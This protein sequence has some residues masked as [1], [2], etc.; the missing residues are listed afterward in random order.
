MKKWPLPTILTAALLVAVLLVYAVSF[1]VRFNEAAIRVRFGSATEASV[2]KEPGIHWKLPPPFE[3]VRKFD[4]RLQVL[5]TPETETKTKDDEN[6]IVGAFAIWRIDDP[7][8]FYIRAKSEEEARKQLRKRLS[9]IRQD[10]MSRYRMADLVNLDQA[11]V[12]RT[13]NQ[14]E[15][16]L[17]DGLKDGVSKDYGIFVESVQIRRISLPESATSEIFN[18][19]VAERDKQAQKYREEGEADRAGIRSGAESARDTIL[20]FTNAKATA[21]E[22]EGIAAS[23][24]IL[25]Q[26]PDE[27]RDFYIFQ[28]RLDALGMA[29]REKATIFLDSTNEL[30]T[31]FIQPPTVDRRPLTAAASDDN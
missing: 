24:R 3:T 29:L 4:M 28:R 25:A 13:F 8:K 30:M 7:L 31:T 16:E 2:V 20:A 9:G 19:M 15:A 12:D 23:A 21:I 22:S 5:D 17:R 10:V 14:I 18:A 26:I 1:Q 11:V 27:Y 6:L